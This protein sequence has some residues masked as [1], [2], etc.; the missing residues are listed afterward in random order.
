MNQSKKDSIH[1]STGGGSISGSAIGGHQNSV[2]NLNYASNYPENELRSLK[3][4]LVS[5]LT[6][7]QQTPVNGELPNNVETGAMAARRVNTDVTLRGKIVSA[8]KV[9]GFEALEKVLE[10]PAAAFF[11]AALKEFFSD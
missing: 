9:G 5:L 4:E 8:V 3:E 7:V 6:E 1:V 2:N 10:H 11:I